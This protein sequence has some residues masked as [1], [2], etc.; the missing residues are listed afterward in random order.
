MNSIEAE[1]ARHIGQAL[2]HNGVIFQLLVHF[3]QTKLFYASI[4]TY[5]TRPES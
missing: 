2:Q 3:H 1:G 4:D 5:T